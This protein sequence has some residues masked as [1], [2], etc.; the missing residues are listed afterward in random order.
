MIC[1]VLWYLNSWFIIKKRKRGFEII[2]FDY[3][4]AKTSNDFLTK[5]VWSVKKND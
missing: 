2:L 4:Y 1:K 5:R 3:E